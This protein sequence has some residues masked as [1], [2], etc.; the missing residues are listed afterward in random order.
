MKAGGPEALAVG[1]AAVVNARQRLKRRGV[2]IM[3]VP[4]FITEDTSGAL[5]RQS[6]FLQ[7]NLLR[8]P[9]NGPLVDPQ[10]PL[11]YS[12]GSSSASA[13]A[14]ASASSSSDASSELVVLSNVAPPV[15][16]SLK[17]PGC[18]VVAKEAAEEE[19]VVAA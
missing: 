14:T 15:T 16:L 13:A 1:M 9:V 6:K 8:C 2:D 18:V 7:F 19:A 17:P 11:S 5:G 10:D 4:A 12:F 3:V